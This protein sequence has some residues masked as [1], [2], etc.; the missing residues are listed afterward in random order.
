MIIGKILFCLIAVCLAACSLKTSGG[1]I[2]KGGNDYEIFYEADSGGLVT[3]KPTSLF[4]QFG[5]TLKKKKGESCFMAA[6]DV[7]TLLK[8]LRAKEVF[9]ESGECFDNVYYFSPLISD[10]V[11]VNGQ[12]VNL[13]VAFGAENGQAKVATPINFGGY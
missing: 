10:Y 9:K 2:L 3:E 5:A 11:I 4:L 7:D 8:N 13:H 6:N 12:K 1:T